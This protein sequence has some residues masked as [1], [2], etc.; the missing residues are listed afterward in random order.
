MCGRSPLQGKP[1]S[2]DHSACQTER[3][4]VSGSTHHQENLA[5]A[6]EV[7]FE[8]ASNP[9]MRSSPGR[10]QAELS[11][12]PLRVWPGT[13]RLGW[14]AATS[15]L[16]LAHPHMQV[17]TGGARAWVRTKLK[18]LIHVSEAVRLVPFLCGHFMER[19]Q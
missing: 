14:L 8:E 7:E 10:A 11:H 19:L 5:G 13:C 2:S 9:A 6:L 4:H 16:I 1:D 17:N 12:F 18:F 3:T 15:S